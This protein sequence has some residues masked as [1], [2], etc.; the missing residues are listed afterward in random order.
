M[1]S[2][3]AKFCESEGLDFCDD[4]SGR[5][6]YG[7][8]CIGIIC[9]NPLNVLVRLCDFIVDTGLDASFEDL[10]GDAQ[11]DNMGHSMILY[12]PRLRG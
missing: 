7:K 12:F 9:D 10:L 2:L 5:Y 8:K 1:K 3:I 11:L 6:M 4:Y